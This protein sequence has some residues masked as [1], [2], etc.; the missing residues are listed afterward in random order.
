MNHELYPFDPLSGTRDPIPLED[1]LSYNILMDDKLTQRF[2]LLVI[3]LI[4]GFASAA[5]GIGGG[6]V[7]VPF[8]ALFAG[9]AI[10][11]AV[12]T[13][14]VSIV[15]IAL[16]GLVTHYVMASQNIQ[17]LVAALTTLG[18]IIGAKF[19]AALANRLG[20]RTLQRLLAALLVLVGLKYARILNIPTEAVADTMVYPALVGLGLLAGSGSAL[21]GI[22]GGVIMVPVF[23][24]FFGLTMHQAVATSLTVIVP[25]TV[26]GAVFHRKFGNVDKEALACLIPVALVGAVLGGYTANSLPGA[27]LKMIFGFFVIATGLRL[28]VRKGS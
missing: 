9:F 20:T 12:G 1:R 28:L 5:L 21:F 17:L 6:V 8:L 25:T 16:V 22:G 27:T 3:G 10:H 2:K 24:L 14:L 7:M 4:A 11:K 13:S 23:N 15:P 26:A 18:S 19:G